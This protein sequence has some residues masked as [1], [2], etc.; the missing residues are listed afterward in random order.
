MP[1]I[2]MPE[3]LDELW[4]ILE[5]EP[6]TGLYAGGTDLLV[7][8]RKG[9]CSHPSLTCLE[10][11]EAL[12][13]IREEGD[14]I[15]IGACT[16]FSHIIASDPVRS[17]VPLLKKGLEVLGSPHIRN[18]GTL[19]GNIATA[20]P[21]GDSLPPLYALDADL[22]ISSR[23]S[24]RNVPIREFI[25]GP[26][27]IDLNEGEILSAIRMRKTKGFSIQHYEKVGQRQAL[28][29]SVVSLGVM[30]NTD[31]QGVIQDVRL[32]LGSVGPTVIRPH[33][34]EEAL[35]GRPLSLS[36]LKEA[37]GMIRDAVRPID[38]IR[39]TARYRRTVAGNLLLR[40]AGDRP[41]PDRGAAP[42]KENPVS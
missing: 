4:S 12:Q 24:S 16:P 20:S 26:G 31:E 41:A 23:G 21:A 9:I 17:H 6:K 14:A 38:D 36:S 10:R 40:L 7:R 42:G 30:M 22:E 1:L 18:M 25:Q 32:A 13:G 29:I 37:A 19:G 3:H 35:R 34:A 28:S 27:R 15:V 11:I 8:L 5:Q 2:R 33:E 39:A